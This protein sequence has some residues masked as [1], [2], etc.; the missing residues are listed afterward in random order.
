MIPS[1]PITGILQCPISQDTMREPV[2]LNC[3]EGHNFDRISIEPLLRNNK[4]C[5]VCLGP[6]TAFVVNRELQ[7]LVAA[8]SLTSNPLTNRIEQLSFD[9]LRDIAKKIIAY[10]DEEDISEKPDKLV[11]KIN[12]YTPQLSSDLL[13]QLAV[14]LVQENLSAQFFIG[15]GQLKV[16]IS[17][18]AYTILRKLPISS[19]NPFPVTSPLTTSLSY[20]SGVSLTPQKPPATSSFVSSPPVIVSPISTK[21]TLPAIAFGKEKWATYFGDVGEEPPLPPDIDKILAAQC[22]FL[23]GKKVS[24]T[25]LLVLIPKTVNGRPLNLKF[26]GELVQKPLQGNA[27]KYK[28]FYLGEYTDPPAPKSH[29]ALMTRDVVEG[30]RGRSYSDQQKL[31]TDNNQK[32]KLP[33]EIP[34]VLDAAVCIFMEYVRTGTRLYSDNPYTF[35]WCQEK[36]DANWYLVVGGF[37]AAGLFVHRGRNFVNVSSGV[38]GLRKF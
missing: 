28:N 6:A 1:N 15:L 21:I 8:L 33:Y 35:T 29:W 12:Y 34:T 18:Q 2:R 20:P 9:D 36:Y 37:S 38:G 3:P 19:S 13:K 24:E 16:H 14:F 30:S 23:P 26:L 10:A 31:M 22:P 5:P 25:H 27:T 4:T 32:A 11:G 17:L 7:A